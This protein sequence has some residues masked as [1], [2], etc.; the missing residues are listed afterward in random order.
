[1]IHIATDGSGDF[2]S[3]GQ[4]LA[5]LPPDREEEI[6]FFIHK[7]IYK[8]QIVITRPRGYAFGRVKGRDHSH[9]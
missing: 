5:C 3:V 6:V 1:M 8:E 7:G 9:L 4:A 2:R